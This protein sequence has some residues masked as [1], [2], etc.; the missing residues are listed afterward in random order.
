[1]FGLFES[2]PKIY[3]DLGGNEFKSKYTSIQGAVLLDVR[4][5]GEFK[6]DRLKG[7]RNMDIMSPSFAGQVETLDKSKAYFLYCRSGNRSGNACTVMAEKGFKA[8][9]LKRGIG[10]WPE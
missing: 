5:P 8:Y 6:G 4:S 7:A 10:D 9:N 2:E 1:M 3:E